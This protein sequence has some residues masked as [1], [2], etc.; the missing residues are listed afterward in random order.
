MEQRTQQYKVVAMSTG[1]YVKP[2][3]FYVNATS[4]DEA[5]TI[6]ERSGVDYDVMTA[7]V[8]SR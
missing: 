5:L 3:T 6:V 1:L 8:V 7:V 2:K 4:T